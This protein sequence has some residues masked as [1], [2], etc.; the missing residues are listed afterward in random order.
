MYSTYQFPGCIYTAC[1]WHNQAWHTRH[2]QSFWQCYFRASV[3]EWL[4]CG[5]HWVH[6]GLCAVLFIQDMHFCCFPLFKLLHYFTFPLAVKKLP[7]SLW[8][9]PPPPSILLSSRLWY[10]QES[11][12]PSQSVHGELPIGGDRVVPAQEEAADPK[13]ADPAQPQ[14]ALRGCKRPGHQDPAQKMQLPQEQRVSTCTNTI[15]L[16]GNCQIANVHTT[17]F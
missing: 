14:R 3:R 9:N 5:S 2:H 17:K 1:W 12:F 4:L 15:N 13:P 11:A 6:I 10:Y 7:S 8:S 16:G